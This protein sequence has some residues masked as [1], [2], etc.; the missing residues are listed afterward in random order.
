MRVSLCV[1]RVC[2]RVPTCVC[3]CTRVHEQCPVHACVLAWIHACPRVPTCIVR[4]SG[5]ARVDPV[6]SRVHM[7]ACVPMRV[8]MCVHVCSFPRQNLLGPS[9]P[10][11]GQIPGDTVESEECVHCLGRAS[12]DVRQCVSGARQCESVLESGG[13]P[14]VGVAGVRWPLHAELQVWALSSGL[15]GGA[16]E[17]LWAAKQ[18][19]C[20]SALQ[21]LPPV[22]AVSFQVRA[23]LS[24]LF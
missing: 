17:R 14:R 1:I 22:S 5:C 3:T 15:C 23:G 4:A 21:S 6:C 11:S 20:D 18:E 13:A 9:G 19:E 7:C 12:V 16:A 8:P 10:S 24:S 2:T